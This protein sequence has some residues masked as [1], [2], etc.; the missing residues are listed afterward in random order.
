MTDLKNTTLLRKDILVR[1]RKKAEVQ[2][3]LIYTKESIDHSQLQYFE[4][5]KVAPEVVLVSVG[6]I[7]VINWKNITPPFEAVFDGIRGD[8]GITDESQIE[9]IVENA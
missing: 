4:V 3:D 6:D 8:Y 7:V 5:L 2:N 9:C 1:N